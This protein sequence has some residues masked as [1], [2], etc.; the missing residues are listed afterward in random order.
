MNADKDRWESY[1]DKAGR[2]H[3]RWP[4]T[5]AAAERGGR[6]AEADSRPRAGLPSPQQTS[7]A[8]LPLRG[9]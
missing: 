5:N 9:K 3:W 1:T 7:F 8:L 2:R 6:D 4:A